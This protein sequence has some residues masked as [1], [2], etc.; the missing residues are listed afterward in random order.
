MAQPSPDRLNLLYRVSQAFN[1]S[2]D[3]DEVLKRVMDEVIATTRAERGF[4]VLREPDGQFVFRAARGMEQTTVDAPEFQISRSVVER[5]VSEGK[6]RLTSDAQQDAWLG[7]RESVRGLKL[8]A[9]VCVPLVLKGTAFGAIY[10]DNR[11]QAGIF[12]SGDLELLNAIAASAAVAI[13]NARLFRDVQDKLRHLSM[14]HTISGELT[15]TLDLDAVLTTCLQRVQE[16]FASAAASILLVE[17]TDL[18]FRV[19]SGARAAEAKRVRV[20]FGRGIAGWVVEHRQGVIVNDVQHD[21]RFYPEV[22]R[23]TGYLTRSLMAA[24]LIVNERAIG[25]V[26]VSNKPDDY[27]AA[28]LDLLGT[29]AGSAAIAI[30]NARLYLVAVEKG[31]LEREMQV[32]REVQAS[33]LPRTIPHISGW[34]FAAR[35]QPQREV[36]GDY[37]DF[38]PA[39]DASHLGLVI[40]DVT[41]K[42][43]PAALFMALTRS[44]VRASVVTASSP[45]D[46]IQRA[47]RLVCA[48]ATGGMF[49]T[50]FYGELNT[51]TGELAYVNAGHNAPLLYQA[52][53][54]QLVKLIR[55]G[56]PLGVEYWSAYEQRSVQLQPGDFVVLYTDGV[57]DAVNAQEQEFGEERL[58]RVI[59]E[60][61]A[62]P[63]ADMLAAVVRAL[64]AFTGATAPFDDITLVVARRV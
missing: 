16:A 58:R 14:L 62:A 11:M 47:N 43:M 59:L 29:I 60:N 54:A 31:R 33:L 10:V 3:L 17:G 46:G 15:S 23:H 24:P 19:A 22:D 44:I 28:D 34:E 36:A 13:D 21:P 51:T 8:R 30:E 40:A 41:D 27:T 7:T 63:A 5:V 1:S 55:T 42:G 20:P 26:E 25:A 6:A 49:V 35:W 45:L 57:T 18:V 2:L 39:E 61:R 38:I 37:Y 9:I 50:L 53:L 32:A 12:T 48:D 52:G 4:V 64:E 56:M